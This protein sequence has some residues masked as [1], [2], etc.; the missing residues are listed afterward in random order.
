MQTTI[1]LL[2]SLQK[3]DLE[4]GKLEDKKRAIPEK[5]KIVEN[6]FKQ[7]ERHLAEMQKELKAKNVEIDGKELEVRSIEEKVKRLQIQLNAATSNKEYSTLEREIGSFK[8][9]KEVIEDSIL[10]ILNSTE[11]MEGEISSL[12]T[13]VKEKQEEFEKEK[14]EAARLDAELGSEI[15]KLDAH[16]QD[17]AR[18]IDAD[19]IEAYG[20]LLTRYEA[21]VVVPVVGQSCGGCHMTLTP[22]TINLLMQN[23]RLVKCKSCGRILYLNA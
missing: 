21:E 16:R 7:A 10:G 3:L 8:A 18:Q 1:N 12:K 2:L 5:L 13:R 20:R 15:R 9:D 6:E 22:Q 23:E 17:L 4:K 11:E 19:T 14:V